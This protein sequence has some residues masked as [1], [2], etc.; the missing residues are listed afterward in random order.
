MVNTA[1]K[2][3]AATAATCIAA[4]AQ[5]QQAPDFSKVEIKTTQLADDFFTLEGQGGTISVLT[6]PDGVDSEFA[7]LTD[8]LVTAIKKSLANQFAF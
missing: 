2:F 1:L 3:L 8:I 5:G 6:G 7:P 4:A